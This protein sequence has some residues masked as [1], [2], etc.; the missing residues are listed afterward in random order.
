MS[1]P[2]ITS[3]KEKEQA[4]AGTRYLPFDS[5]MCPAD[6]KGQ[7]LAALSVK[8]RSCDTQLFSRD[9]LQRRIGRC[10]R[11][12]PVAELP[13]LRLFGDGNYFPYA[14]VNVE[15]IT[16]K[17]EEGIYDGVRQNMADAPFLRFGSF[18]S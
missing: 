1:G 6:R 9:K 4:T 18:L 2:V 10:L 7:Q 14:G 11:G 8:K 13:P 3:S 17:I 16:R 12:L 15:G 5:Q